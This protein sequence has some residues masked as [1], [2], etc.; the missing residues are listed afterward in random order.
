MWTG[1]AHVLKPFELFASVYQYNFTPTPT[2]A[3]IYQCEEYSQMA[4][5]K[6]RLKNSEFRALMTK[7]WFFF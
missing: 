1:I 3:P 4:E 6:I 2:L 5:G 7:I